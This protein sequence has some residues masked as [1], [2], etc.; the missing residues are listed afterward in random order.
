MS[1]RRVFVDC[2]DTLILWPSE[3]LRAGDEPA[4]NYQLLSALAIHRSGSPKD[5]MI[6]WSGGGADYA[7]RWRRTIMPW[8]DDSMS[9]DT[10]LPLPG[11]ICIDDMPIRVA[12]TSVYTWEEFI[13]R[14]IPH[15]TS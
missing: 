4:I 15:F 11:D 6:V 13:N 8:A 3:V 10:H 1:S 7:E 5:K 2:D 9:K 14:G 12:A